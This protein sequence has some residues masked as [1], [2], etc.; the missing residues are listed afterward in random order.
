MKVTA[1]TNVLVSATFWKGA[2]DKIISKAETKEMQLI[3]S[4]DII[5]EYMSVLEYDEIKNKIKD[6]NL[7]MKLTLRKIISI[8]KNV[9]PK[10]KLN[11]IK[12]DPDDDKIL[13]CAKAGKVNYIISNDRHLLNLKEY[14][15]I[16]VLK[17]EDFLKLLK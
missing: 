8:S 6:K 17:P 5:R 10:T 16:K 11:I 13:E 2:S 12:D 14:D 7:E 15:G 3:L 4:K 9:E 1:D